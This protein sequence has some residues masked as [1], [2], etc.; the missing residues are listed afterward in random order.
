LTPYRG[1]TLGIK[2]EKLVLGVLAAANADR[3]AV[4]EA[5]TVT[6]LEAEP[7]YR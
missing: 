4:R 2:I 6:R 1:Q 5:V 3:P 7:I